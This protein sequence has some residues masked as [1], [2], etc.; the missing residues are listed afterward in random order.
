M[1]ISQINKMQQLGFHRFF[2]QSTL[3]ENIESHLVSWKK[4]T[5]ALERSNKNTCQSHIP[6]MKSVL[7]IEAEISVTK[8]FITAKL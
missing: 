2:N 5:P 7:L 8:V 4:M 1:Y 3:P 6:I